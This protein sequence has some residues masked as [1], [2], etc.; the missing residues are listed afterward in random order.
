MVAI[1]GWQLV[2]D[3]RW[4]AIGGWQLVG[5]NWLMTIGWLVAIGGWQLVGDNWWVALGGWQLV[6]DNWLVAA[7]SEEEE[8]EGADTILKPP[9]TISAEWL[10][11]LVLFMNVWLVTFTYSN[12]AISTAVHLSAHDIENMSGKTVLKAIF[13]S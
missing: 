6:G 5:D 13:Q 1:G 3:N 8:G 11:T 7:R 9:S 10:R 12:C 4:V 2:G